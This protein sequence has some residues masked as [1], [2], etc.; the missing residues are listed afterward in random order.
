MSA[1]LEFRTWGCPLDRLTKASAQVH[2]C[3]LVKNS[4]F[5]LLA[6]RLQAHKEA[7]ESAET[8]VL[9]ELTAAF[10]AILSAA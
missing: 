7:L 6:M 2:V 8:S 1:H 5:V 9:S 3:A 4:T 10:V